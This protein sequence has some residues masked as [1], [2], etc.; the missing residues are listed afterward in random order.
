MLEV[1]FESDKETISFCE[2]LFQ[3]NKQIELHWKTAEE[4]GN[5]LQL[6]NQSDNSHFLET[7]A[8]AMAGVYMSHRLTGMIGFVIRRF[9]YYTSSA[10]IERIMDLSHWIILG[11]DGDS[12]MVRNNQDPGQL[13][14]S[15]FLANIQHTGE[16]H[17]DSVINFQLKSFKDDIIYY[18]GLAIDEFKR[19]E[20]HQ[21][22]LDMLR[23]YVSKRPSL[24]DT[25]YVIQGETFTFFRPDGRQ[26]STMELQ[27]LMQ[28]EPLY[29]TG[30]DANELN[31][32]PL[33]T[34]APNTIKIYGD[35]P[36]EPKTLTI[37]N[38]FQ[39]R[40]EF[41]SLRHFPFPLHLKSK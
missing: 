4:W 8:R 23:G 10:E 31:L 29:I 22:F 41:T 32:S 6:D 39:E 35:D 34:M 2:R 18:V 33:I 28:K 37:I 9:Y 19:E 11:D 26:Y 16:L 15:I 14:D 13:L 40:A 1:Y 17:F 5:H 25:V 38:I 7:V 27:T 30:L 3:L 21:A 36:S 20:D 24:M 12:Q